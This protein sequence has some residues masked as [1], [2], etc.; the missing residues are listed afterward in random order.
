MIRFLL[1]FTDKRYQTL[2]SLN[3]RRP[4]WGFGWHLFARQHFKTIVKKI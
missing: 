3:L 2:G 1:V 4:I